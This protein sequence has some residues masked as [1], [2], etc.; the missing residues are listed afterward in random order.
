MVFAPHP[1]DES[2]ACSIPIQR[3]VAAGASVRV[4]YATD[5]ENNPWPQRVIE[6]KWRIGQTERA[7]W[8]K[9]R[10]LEAQ[11]ALLALGLRLEDVR[12]LG[13]PDQ[14]LTNLL[15]RGHASTLPMLQSLIEDFAPTDILF[16]STADAHPDHNALAV[17]LLVIL[18]RIA[19]ETAPDRT[20]QFAVHGKN[21][22][23]F[24]DAE[25]LAGT[26]RE[27]ATKVRA[28]Q[29]H[30]TQLRLSRNRFLRYAERP[31][32]FLAF[33]GPPAAISEPGI[34]IVSREPQRLIIYLPQR[35][36]I[37]DRDLSLLTIGYSYRG[38]LRSAVIRLS[39]KSAQAE[40][41]DGVTGT[42]LSIAALEGSCLT[43]MEINIP[44]RGLFSP[45]SSIFLKL[46]R[47]SITF[48]DAGWCEVPPLRAP[49]T[50]SKP[51]RPVL[52]G[53]LQVV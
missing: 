3:A 22:G 18:R 53:S 31:E 7:R 29:C 20:W 34:Q 24:A 6:R 1:D 11:A 46:S 47:R 43:G 38:G 19:P 16:P 50:S 52:Q 9:L 15:M 25:P 4:M 44:T 41:A 32:Q 39:A 13:L 37:V 14:G 28:I 30:R 5:G 35:K 49:V 27:V 10:Q 26:P 33:D 12:F 48:N 42:G 2:L 40:M 23:F 36:K 51:G 8:G 17:M 21:A 45:D